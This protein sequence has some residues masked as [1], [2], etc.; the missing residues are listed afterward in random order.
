[1]EIDVKINFDLDKLQVREVKRIWFK[2]SGEKIKT[3]ARKYAPKKRYVLQNSIGLFPRFPNGL[4]NE[5][6]VGS[7]NVKYA[8]I[9]ELGGII[10][11]RKA[12]VLS[13]T[14]GGKRY[15][16]KQVRIKPKKYFQKAFEDGKDIVPKEFA[17]AVDIVISKI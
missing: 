5:V 7:R 8:R 3:Q 6:R 17:K 1:M 14:E 11:P 4:E 12:K 13:W 15:F 9:Q 2:N 16:A 10:R